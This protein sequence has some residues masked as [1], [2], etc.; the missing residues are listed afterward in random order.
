MGSELPAGFTLDGPATPQSVALPPGFTLDQ[1]QNAPDVSGQAAQDAI[2]RGMP[3]SGGDFGV[4]AFQSLREMGH[5]IAERLA[6][7]FDPEGQLGIKDKV[8]KEFQNQ[9][10]AYNQ[11]YN[12]PSSLA[13][14]NKKPILQT[15]G[16][17]AGGNL[18]FAALPEIK[19]GSKLAT[20][21]AAGL[22]GAAIGATVPQ[23]EGDSGA[24]AP[25]IGA[26]S[27]LLMR[28]PVGWLMNKAINKAA[29][30]P[31]LRSVIDQMRIPKA[32]ID[33]N[34]PYGAIKNLADNADKFPPGS[35]E[36]IQ[37]GKAKAFVN[38]IESKMGTL[39]A[40][41]AL[42]ADVG[43]K[44]LNNTVKA[45]QLYAK[46]DG[47][48]DA[49]GPINTAPLFA[50]LK[51]I[52]EKPVNTIN[53]GSNSGAVN[54][55]L[56]VLGNESAPRASLGTSSFYADKPD[57][58]MMLGAL[59]QNKITYSTLSAMR[60]SFSKAA[61][62]AQGDPASAV[63]SELSK[64]I[65][66]FQQDFA[67]SQGGD[68]AKADAAA[69]DYY[70]N[71][72]VPYKDEGLA[73]LLSDKTVNS[74]EIYKM[75]VSY[76]KDDPEQAARLY[77][78][79]SPSGQSAVKAGIYG[80]AL[81]AATDRNGYTDP[82]LV[83]HFIDSIPNASSNYLTSPEDKKILEGLANLLSVDAAPLGKG[84]IYY[85]R[86]LQAYGLENMAT[87]ELGRGL[88]QITMPYFYNQL[89][90]GIYRTPKMKDYLLAAEKL[91]PNSPDAAKVALKFAE[92]VRQMGVHDA[93][94]AGQ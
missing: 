58:K 89:L 78:L 59:N 81:S 63:Y 52:T 12:Q 44:F 57:V 67:K 76:T 68:L 60:D 6:E 48:A 66:N 31:E 38:T 32:E 75:F 73:K 3:F 28:F 94:E 33:Q 36:A 14:P 74:G 15:M 54:K 51:A 5:G 62:D 87:G 88:K 10:K 25:L 27:A 70:K 61:N 92:M 90:N 42:R 72:V 40:A 69:R 20:L 9:E 21:G 2:I 43:G 19:F 16:E 7:S 82:V 71:N 41:L 80:D 24:T 64:A 26:G 17:I 86:Y 77:K 35:P 1:Q 50:Q 11:L 47:I 13:A 55:V 84:N 91:N 49:M 37:A 8:L 93:A 56:S 85:Q 39:D 30:A 46:R 18:P 22:E 34:G 79:I 45:G 23:G 53:L 29:N 65:D 4:G 83:R